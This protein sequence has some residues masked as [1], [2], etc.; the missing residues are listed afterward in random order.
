MTS[1]KKIFDNPT[2]WVAK[3]I[4]EYVDSDGKKGH[5]WRG[6]TTLLLTTRGRKSGKFR[7]TALIYGQDGENYLIVASN[8]GAANHPFWYLNLVE[9][10]RIELQVGADRFTANAR[11]ADEKEKPRLWKIMSGLFPQYD[12][13]Q[14]KAGRDI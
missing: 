9:D 3:H 8:G 10:P 2:G 1:K 5:Q 6:Q 11:T 14:A 4:Q 12:Q 7:R 13:Y